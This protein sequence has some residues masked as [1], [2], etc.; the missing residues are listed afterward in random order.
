MGIGFVCGI[1]FRTIDRCYMRFWIVCLLLAHGL[2]QAEPC[3]RN[4]GKNL[5]G[6]EALKTFIIQKM[7]QVPMRRLS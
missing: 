1:G 6:L 7:T 3:A 5:K 2:A 4:R